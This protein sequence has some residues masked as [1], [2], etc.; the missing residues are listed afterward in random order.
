MHVKGSIMYNH[1]VKARGL[2]KKCPLIGEAEKIRFMH[3]VEP[4]PFMTPVLAFPLRLPPELGA[5]E[6]IDYD[7][8][9]EKAFVEPMQIVLSAIGWNATQVSSLEAFFS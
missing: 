5:N 2:A 6:Y 8:Q 1:I 7:L 4:N 9:F 3:L